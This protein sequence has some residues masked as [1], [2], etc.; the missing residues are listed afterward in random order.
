MTTKSAIHTRRFPRL[1]GALAVLAISAISGCG[2]LTAGGF[3]AEAT[4]IVSGDAAS[5][6][7]SPQGPLVAPALVGPAPTSHDVGPEGEVEVEFLAYLI[8][9]SGAALQLGEEIRVRVDLRGENE[10]DVVSEIVPATRYTGLRIVF[11]D[12]EVEVNGLVVDGVPVPE[13]RVE[14]EDLSLLVERPIDL[15]V[16]RGSNVELVVDLNTPTWLQAVDPLTGMV[17]ES[18]FG[19][20]VG[21]ITR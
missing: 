15:D 13:V 8:T 2:N 7:A 16:R 18:V 12:I 10:M 20:L 4:V 5:P 11:T 9:E 3:T 6:A 14:L 17:D 19:D 1:T 21:V